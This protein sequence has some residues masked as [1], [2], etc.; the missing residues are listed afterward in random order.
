MTYVICFKQVSQRDIARIEQ[1]S[2][3]QYLSKVWHQEREWRL[4]AS[5]FGDICRATDRRDKLKL[6]A[7]IYR[8]AKLKN[9]AVL[10][11]HQHEAVAR[12]TFKRKMGCSVHTCGLFIDSENNYLAA[13]PDG[14]VGENCILEIKCPYN[15]RDRK[16]VADKFFPFLTEDDEGSLHLKQ[17]HS[18]YMQI[19]GQ[20]N[21][22][23]KEKCFFVVY[24]FVDIFVEEIFV[25]REYWNGC[26]LPKLQLFYEKHYRKF[27]AEKL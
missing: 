21:V 3:K 26:M 11:G 24:T 25:E 9:P 27:L 12:Q 10:H 8:P 16:I 19:Q 15:G 18:Y 4:T 17:N 2:T 22:C 6:C 14:I 5:R 23:K 7:S 20:L 1:T 13:T